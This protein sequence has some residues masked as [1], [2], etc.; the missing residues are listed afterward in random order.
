MSVLEDLQLASRSS[1]GDDN[2]VDKNE[3]DNDQNGQKNF[4]L[5]GN[6]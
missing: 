2:D 5:T 4:W 6:I 1:N 3:N